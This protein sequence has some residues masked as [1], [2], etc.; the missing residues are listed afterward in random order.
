MILSFNVHWWKGCLL[1]WLNPSSVFKQSFNYLSSDFPH[2]HSIYSVLI[3]YFHPPQVT[4]ITRPLCAIAVMSSF[5]LAYLPPLLNVTLLLL[6]LPV[7]YSSLQHPNIG[8]WS[9]FFF[10]GGLFED[11]NVHPNDQ[12]H[13][14]AAGLFTSGF[15][16]YGN[17]KWQLTGSRTLDVWIFFSKKKSGLAIWLWNGYLSLIPSLIHQCIKHF[18]I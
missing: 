12:T 14:Q 1:S 16:Q 7:N 18:P 2:T 10:L 8:S 6:I 4:F 3:Y 13:C 5:V 15:L 11:V 17:T 9:T